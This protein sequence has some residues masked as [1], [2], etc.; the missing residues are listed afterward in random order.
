MPPA[1]PS[2]RGLERLIV[3]ALAVFVLDQVSKL[4]VA[5]AL[6]PDGSMIVVPGFVNLILSRNT[7]IVFGILNNLDFAYKAALVTVLSVVALLGVGYFVFQSKEQSALV[8]LSLGLILGGALGNVVDRV[9]LGYVVDFIDVYYRHHH[10]HTFNVA[11]S[12]ISVGVAILV[13]QS[14]TGRPGAEEL[15]RSESKPP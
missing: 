13:L 14:L 10:W 2:L 8:I 9:R 15:G 3:T 12:A 6:E 4:W 11:D 5:R 7:G 1:T